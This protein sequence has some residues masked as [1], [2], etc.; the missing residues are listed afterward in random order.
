M[1]KIYVSKSLQGLA[2]VVIVAVLKRFNISLPD[3]QINALAM[4]ALTLVGAV[5]SAYGAAVSHASPES[6]LKIGRLVVQFAPALEA[7]AMSKV[8]ADVAPYVAPVPDQ[9]QAP[10]PTSVPAPVAT[11]VCPAE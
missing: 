7:V 8:L 4:D 5:W 1:T 6:P 11:P 9:V 3:A 10:A 2:V